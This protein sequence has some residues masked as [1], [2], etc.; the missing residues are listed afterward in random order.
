[1]TR[2][3]FD[4]V[5]PEYAAGRPG[6]PEALFHAIERQTG[7]PLAGSDVIDVGAGTGISTRALHA[8][9]CR[10]TAVDNSLPMLRRLRL[11]SPGVPAVF[12][13]GHRL[14]FADGVADLVT[15]AQSWHWTDPHRSVPEAARVLRPGGVLALWWNVPDLENCAWAAAQERRIA[16][17]AP[18]Y[19]GYQQPDVE[20]LS[21][22]PFGLRTKRVVLRWARSVP[23][24]THLLDLRSRSYIASLPRPVLEAFIANERAVL[25]ATFPD[26][27]LEVPYVV[28]LVVVW[29]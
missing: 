24:E 16:A 11:D 22:P 23:V 13:D 9:G 12:G 21:Q 19:H 18:E 27:M 29:P 14:P 4:S 5:A 10:V 17:V 20:P 25:T 2:S 3:R 7:R 28:R 6:Y 8:A 1:M 15:Y 26:G